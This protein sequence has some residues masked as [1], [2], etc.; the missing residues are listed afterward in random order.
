MLNKINGCRHELNSGEYASSGFR[1]NARE[2]DILVS[3]DIGRETEQG[4]GG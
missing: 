4:E 2:W 3:P 1:A